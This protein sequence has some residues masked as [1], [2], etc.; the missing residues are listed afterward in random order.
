[1]PNPPRAYTGS[2]PFIFV[3]YAHSDR[4]EVI[5]EITRLIDAGFTRGTTRGSRRGQS[6]RRLE[7]LR[8]IIDESDPNTQWGNNQRW[9]LVRTEFEIALFDGDLSKA[10]ELPTLAADIGLHALATILYI[11]LDDPQAD[12]QLVL[13]MA[14]PEYTRQ[15]WA[16]YRVSS[17]REVREDPRYIQLRDSLGYTDANKLCL[18]EQASTLPPSTGI[19]CDPGNYR[20]EAG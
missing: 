3:C 14:H 11:R 4:D 5:E 19:S 16:H 7:S 9:S 1:M 20:T 12:E 8:V 18:C 17:T 13:A 2:K 15:W 6:G 10:A